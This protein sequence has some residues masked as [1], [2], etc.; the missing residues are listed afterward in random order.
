[1]LQIVVCGLSGCTTFFHVISRTARF[2]KKE[3]LHIKCAFW[4]SLQFNVWG[5]PYSKKNWAR[6]DQKCILVFMWSTPYV[7]QISMTHAFSWQIFE[8]Y[9]DIK[10]HENPSIGNR[11]VSCGQTERETDVQDES[12]SHFSLFCANAPSKKLCV[13]TNSFSGFL[14][15]I[16]LMWRIGWAHNNARK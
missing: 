13:R 9:S 8:K 14:T 12:N 4:F 7:C 5:F 16:L 1:M 3:I 11:V 15:L 10:L 6:C 2:P